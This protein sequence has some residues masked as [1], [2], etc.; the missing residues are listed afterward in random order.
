MV[1]AICYAWL[2]DTKMRTK[3][4]AMVDGG[5]D[6]MEM[7]VPVLNVRRGKMWKQRQAA[8]LFHHAGVDASAILFANE[9]CA[10]A[11]FR[12]V[13]LALCFDNDKHDI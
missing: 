9:V 4:N 10:Y 12:K 13:R 1:S 3:R 5:G 7:V 6:T 2:L 8:W 11:P